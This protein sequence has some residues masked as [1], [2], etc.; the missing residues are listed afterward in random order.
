M[1][2]AKH[3]ATTK[4]SPTTPKGPA[5]PILSSAVTDRSDFF[6]FGALQETPATATRTGK[7]ITIKAIVRNHRWANATASG[8]ELVVGNP[9][10][11]P[12]FPEYRSVTLLSGVPSVPSKS[13]SLTKCERNRCDIHAPLKPGAEVS[14]ELTVHS[15]DPS[16]IKVTTSTLDYDRGYLELHEVEANRIIVP[17]ETTGPNVSDSRNNLS[18]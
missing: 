16:D 18:K 14:I 15:A 2:E 6:E 12:P 11:R 9:P 3:N 17:V 4:P 7:D 1:A 8:F 10:S 13:E 5:S